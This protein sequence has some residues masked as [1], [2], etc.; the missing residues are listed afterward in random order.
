MATFDLNTI[1]DVESM[2]FFRGESFIKMLNKGTFLDN[3]ETGNKRRVLCNKNGPMQPQELLEFGRS[4]RA[5]EKYLQYI[6]DR[7]NKN[8]KITLRLKI[9]ETKKN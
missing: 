9:C 8:V 7:Q 3:G 4:L 1:E 5:Y 2:C 6:A